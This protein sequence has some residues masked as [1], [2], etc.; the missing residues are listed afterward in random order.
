MKRVSPSTLVVH[1]GE[2]AS[3]P[4]WTPICTPIHNAVSYTYED[5]SRLDA[6]LAGSQA[7]FVYKT[8]NDQVIYVDPYL[9]DSVG[10]LY[11]HLLYGFKRLTPTLIE[12]EEVEADLIVTTHG[13]GWGS[14][15]R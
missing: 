8:A 14:L 6:V 9:T 4:S 13:H 10:R 2:R 7:G 5:A 11:G 15:R 1:A 12:P 3:R